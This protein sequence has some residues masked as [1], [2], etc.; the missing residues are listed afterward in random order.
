MAEALRALEG[1]ISEVD[2]DSFHREVDLIVNHIQRRQKDDRDVVAI[3]GP[4]NYNRATMKEEV[5]QALPEKEPR[6]SLDLVIRSRADQFCV[7]V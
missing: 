6:L 1:E 7:Y 5:L 3:Y 4:C 2:L